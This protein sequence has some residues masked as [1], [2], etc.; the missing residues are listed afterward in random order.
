[1]E[2][3]DIS[4]QIVN[5]SKLEKSDLKGIYVDLR[6]RFNFYIGELRGEKL[7]FIESKGKENMTPL[8]YS[9]MVNNLEGVFKYPLVFIFDDL[10]YYERNRLLNYGIFFV[11]SGKYVHLPFLIIN[12]KASSHK[13]PKALT[14]VAQCILLLVIQRKNLQKSTLKELDDILPY[15]YATISKTVLLL[16]ELGLCKT[17]KDGRDKFIYFDSG[18]ELWIKA[19]KFIANPVVKKVYCSEILSNKKFTVSSYNALS[20]YSNLNPEEMQTYAIYKNDFIE[21]DFE[22]L[23]EIEGNITLEIWSYPPLDDDYVD[24]LSLALS[25]QDDKDPRVE[26][27][28]KIMINKLW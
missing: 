5:L 9:N 17:Q 18:E 14:P 26:K 2:S 21:A 22:G 20:H 19:Q 16:V 7:I 15:T 3:L 13:T 12:A 25:L 8:R 23:N 1:M 28:I 10:K 4:G 11:V 24:K 6:V 27:E